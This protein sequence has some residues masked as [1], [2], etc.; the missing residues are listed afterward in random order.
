[1]NYRSG[2]RVI[3]LALLLVLSVVALSRIFAGLWGAKTEQ[4]AEPAP[5][6]YRFDMTVAEFGRANR[7]S[8]EALRKV[9]GGLAPR[10][11]GKKLEDTGIPESELAARVRRS[12]A[13]SEEF[14][15]KN[16]VKIP[17]KMALWLVML[18]VAFRLMRRSAVTSTRRKWMYLAAVG[19][20]GVIL[21]NEPSPMNTLT[22]TAALFGQK[23]IIFPPRAVVLTV[24]LVLAVLANKFICAWGCQFGTLQDLLFRLNRDGDE[25][26]ILKQYKL[27]F[28][29]TN[30]VRAAVFILFLSL[31][32]GW[33]LDI[34]APVNPFK[35][36]MP[37]AVTTTGGIML[38][39]LLPA[40]LFIYRPWCHL[41]CP[42]GFL[43]WIAE[44]ASRFKVQ[45]NYDTCIACEQCATSCPSTVM[46]AILKRDR[47]LP[48]C[49]ACGT[50]IEACPT[51]SI[52]FRSGPRQAP[53]AGKFKQ[54]AE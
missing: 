28:A 53:P 31:A 29:V 49:F 32:L 36:Y 45:V 13:M 2:F 20:I 51:R 27:P 34:I 52:E 39:L 15:S 4:A 46:G 43:G 5:V 25:R 35:V 24:F 16:W 48:D 1:M 14:G 7:L 33:G 30:T 11:L 18:A 19:V 23:G 41:F 10:D 38:G 42:F 44:K 26:G 54:T 17:I 3:I 8:T 21:G 40:A 50:C 47:T 9:F 6:A 37:A 22:D 12:T